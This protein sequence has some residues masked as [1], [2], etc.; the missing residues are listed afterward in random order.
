M[1]FQDISHY[2]IIVDLLKP[3]HLWDEDMDF[4]IY[5]DFMQDRYVGQLQKGKYHFDFAIEERRGTDFIELTRSFRRKLEEVVPMFRVQLEEIV[6][7][8]ER[9]VQP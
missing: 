5:K 4:S 7:R 9:G 2:S 8:E 1:I 6:R 3:L